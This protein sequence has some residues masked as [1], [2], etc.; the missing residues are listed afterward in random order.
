MRGEA[1]PELLLE[2]G[3]DPDD[4][5]RER[6]DERRRE[7]P[8]TRIA[9]SSASSSGERDAAERVEQPGSRVEDHVG[10][11]VLRRLADGLVRLDAS[12]RSARGCAARAPRG[13]RAP[14][15]RARLRR[16]GG[17]A[18]GPSTSRC[19]FATAAFALAR[20]S[21]I[22]PRAALSAS[23]TST[24]TAR[25][26]ATPSTPP[27]PSRGRDR[28]RS[29]APRARGW[30]QRPRRLLRPST[31]TSSSSPLPAP[32]ERTSRMFLAL[33]RAPSP[34]ERDRPRR[35]ET[36][37]ERAGW[38]AARARR[39]SSVSVNLTSVPPHRN[40][41]SASADARAATLAELDLAPELT[42]DLVA[43]PEPDRGVAGGGRDSHPEH[44]GVGAE[45][46]QDDPGDRRGSRARR[47]TTAGSCA[48][49]PPSPSGRNPA[50]RASSVV[51]GARLVPIHRMTRRG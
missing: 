4:V 46:L 39:R 33:T 17:R 30:R 6:G 10:G 2:T 27:L 16:E 13:S 22:V 15:R 41:Q 45:E 3:H 29:F 49:S 11:R 51:S 34:P 7:Q 31:S 19:A 28:R 21:S 26:M 25:P 43:D 32:S 9:S 8:V 50:L 47:P 44:R 35:V 12:L 23:G 48:A 18:R 1:R 20:S 24:T 5:R 42:P 38:R 36:R 40:R 14:V 37:G